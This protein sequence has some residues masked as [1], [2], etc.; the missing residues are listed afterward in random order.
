MTFSEETQEHY[1]SR[2]EDSAGAAGDSPN[3]QV[4][5]YH[6]RKIAKM[7]RKSK[8]RKKKSSNSSSE[9]EEKRSKAENF[10]V[11]SGL[12]VKYLTPALHEGR[13]ASKVSDILSGFDD[14]CD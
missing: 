9:R 12:V 3:H 6:P 10:K 13:I 7:K 8:K 5:E 2:D 1:L 11:T 14:S 4:S